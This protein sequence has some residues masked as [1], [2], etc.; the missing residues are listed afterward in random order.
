[1]RDAINHVPSLE[2]KLIDSVYEGNLEKV[3]E[4]I[5]EGANV[6]YRY[7]YYARNYCSDGESGL[8][9]NCYPIEWDFDIGP[10]LAIAVIKNNLR[11]AEYLIQC[12]ADRF[13]EHL[14]GGYY[15]KP[16]V[17]I[18]ELATSKEMKDLL[19]GIYYPKTSL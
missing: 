5:N 19:A 13:A 15:T 14:V 6:N 8:F 11:I 3:K 17:K 2:R 12:E 7:R 16:P 9:E 10:P 4:A 1:M 18:S